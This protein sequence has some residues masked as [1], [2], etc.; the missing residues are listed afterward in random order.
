MSRL[1]PFQATDLFTFNR[2]NLDH[3]TETYSL[4]Y[5]LQYL[6]TWPELCF[7]AENGA[8]SAQSMGYLIGKAEGKDDTKSKE[9]HGHVTAVTVAPEFRRLGLAKMMMDLLE[10]ASSQ[11]Y[12]VSEGLKGIDG[13]VSGVKTKLNSILTTFSPL[14]WLGILH[15][16]LCEAVQCTG[17]RAVSRLAVF[18]IPT[19]EGVLRWRWCG[20]Q[21]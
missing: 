12:N 15:R 10:V 20:R 21:G 5:Y 9:R 16:P 4:G 18:D 19:G 11:M 1:R 13:N 3:F 14:G 8:E 7:I 17:R 6:A 2:I